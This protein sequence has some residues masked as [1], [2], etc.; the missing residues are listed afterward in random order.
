MIWLPCNQPIIL[1]FIHSAL[2]TL[3]FLL[4]LNLG[5]LHLFPLPFTLFF[6]ASLPLSL[7]HHFFREV[8]PP[9]LSGVAL[10]LSLGNFLSV[11]FCCHYSA[12]AI[13]N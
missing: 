2:A 12:T 5:S 6:T 8:S 1:F 9:T 7:N 10:P 13:C 4:L 3:A 11:L